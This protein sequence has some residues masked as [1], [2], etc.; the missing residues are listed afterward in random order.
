MLTISGFAGVAHAQ[1]NPTV[2][3]ATGP[4]TKQTMSRLL[5]TDV[6]RFGNRTVAV[7]DR[8]YVVYSDD[9]GGTWSR[10]K[11]PVGLALLNGV[12]FSD[13]NTVWAV[14]HDS[15][16]LKSTDQGREWT[17]SYS[18]A[19]DQRPLMDIV[20]SDA[21]QGF[22]V[23]AYGA[24]LET[25]DGGKTWSGRKVIPAAQKPAKSTATAGR[26][27]RGAAA[28]NDDDLGKSV[29]EDKHLNAIV[30]IGDGKFFIAG[31][32]GTLLLSNDAGKNWA[33][34]ASPY[35]GSFFGAVQANDGS[36]LVLGLRGNVFRSPD[37]SLKSWE[38]VAT[39]TKASMMG[40]TKLSDGSIVLSGLSGTVL[41]S[42]DNGKTFSAMKSGTIKP[43]AASV[44]GAANALTV[45]GETGARDVP[46]TVAADSDAKK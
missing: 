10:A 37:A 29:D 30:K 5:L 14:G 32:A 43:L 24:F 12:Y 25:T 11:T 26:G 20:F 2:M 42:R 1:V 22:A 15:V 17:Q 46:I 35:K 19:K 28:E 8:G 16:I 41:I 33:R 45:V 18:S 27:N 4:L 9:N 36:V 21:N 3:P 38:V 44:P 39:N 31:E 40:A 13:A 34:V 7:G 6:A 23:G